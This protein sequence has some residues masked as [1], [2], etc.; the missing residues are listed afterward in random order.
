QTGT[1]AFLAS[2]EYVLDQDSLV[3]RIPSDSIQF[4]ENYPVNKITPRSFFGGAGL[5]EE[6]SV[7]IPDGSGVLTHSNNGKVNYPAY[8]QD[9][10]GVDQTMETTNTGTDEQNIRLPIFGMIYEEAAF[11]GVIEEGAAAATI[12]ADISGRLNSYNYVY[13]SF[14]VV[15]KD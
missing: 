3:V 6:G 13:P 5:E 10:F 2:I 4:P 9:V 12:N 1:P 7:F 11:L 15:N 8:K 14:Y